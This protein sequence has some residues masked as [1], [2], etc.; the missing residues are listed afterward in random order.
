MSQIQDQ[1]E[2]IPG[3]DVVMDYFN[4]YGEEHWN[5]KVNPFEDE[6]GTSVVF[7]KI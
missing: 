5:A 6:N 2:N 3:Y 1:L 7:P 4:E